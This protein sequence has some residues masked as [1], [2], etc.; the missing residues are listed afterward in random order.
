M[1]AAATHAPPD[2]NPLPP[3][4]R[5]LDIFDAVAIRGQTQRQAAGEFHLAQ[6]QISRICR[7]VAQYIKTAPSERIDS[8]DFF[9]VL[10]KRRRRLECEL[11]EV[12]AAWRQSCEQLVHEVQKPDGTL[13]KRIIKNA[14]PD[15]RLLRELRETSAQL[16]TVEEAE[17]RAQRTAHEHLQNVAQHAAGMKLL[18]ERAG[19][20]EL[21]KVRHHGISAENLR[22]ELGLPPDADVSRLLADPTP[23]ASP[24]Q[25][26]AP[27]S[28]PS[29]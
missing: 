23:P 12:R 5:D 11:E 22:R 1:P 16:A 14:R 21:L 17:L 15:P 4:T 27:A 3:S 13:E 10:H 24:H 20:S 6:G 29:H 19:G 25:P 26:E 28:T 18:A 7:R 2:D 9:L 8:C